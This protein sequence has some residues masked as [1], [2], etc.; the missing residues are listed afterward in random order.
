MLRLAENV[1]QVCCQSGSPCYQRHASDGRVMV[2]MEYG[3]TV[4]KIPACTSKELM[5]A[6][7]M[8]WCSMLHSACPALH[9][10]RGPPC[11]PS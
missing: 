4:L 1:Q 10:I 9:P 7:T 8:W 3:H 6:F 5:H 11:P 2:C